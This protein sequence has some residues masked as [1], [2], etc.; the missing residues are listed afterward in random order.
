MEITVKRF[1]TDYYLNRYTIS[2]II[3]NS[4]VFYFIKVHNTFELYNINISRKSGNGRKIAK[5]N[6]HQ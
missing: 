6:I 1:V 5:I 3:T 4:V 2:T